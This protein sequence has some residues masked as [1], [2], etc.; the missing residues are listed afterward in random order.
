MTRRHT[1]AFKRKKGKERESSAGD[2]KLMKSEDIVE[3]PVDRTTIT[4]K[5]EEERLH[6]VLKK[7]S[8]NKCLIMFI[9]MN[10]VVYIFLL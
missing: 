4:S 9:L 10:S 2:E 3:Y 7:R 6:I 1:F 8:Y 5:K